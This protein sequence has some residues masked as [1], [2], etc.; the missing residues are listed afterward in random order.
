[1]NQKLAA[2]YIIFD[3]VIEH[4]ESSIG[5]IRNNV[6]YIS[7]VYQHISYYGNK[8]R[9][10]NFD[11]LKN[12]LNRRLIDNIIYNDCDLNLSPKENE[13]KN[14][15]LGLNDAI[16]NQFEFFISMD[17]DEYYVEHQFKNA[18]NKIINDG[19]ESSA[20]EMLTY[21]KYL[22][23]VLDPH[24]DFH[25][26]FIYKINKNFLFG[27]SIQFPVG[28][29]ITR[30]YHSNNFKKFERNELIMHHMSSVRRNF[31]TKLINHGCYCQFNNE[32]EMLVDHYD[33]YRYPNKI[34]FQAN[35]YKF[36]DPKIVNSLFINENFNCI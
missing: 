25:C 3:D 28:A 10:S 6:D 15:N 19:Y 14:R 1:M 21:Y 5:T 22:N 12:L 18:K 34:L 11:L 35:P 20:C 32:I 8:G 36:Y 17:G 30:I 7:I 24:E 16:N 33:N 9:G 23:L 29:D 31:K 2:S 13:I 26:P 4:L 27:N